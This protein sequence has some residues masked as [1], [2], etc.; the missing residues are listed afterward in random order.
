MKKSTVPPAKPPRNHHIDALKGVAIML[1]VLGHSIQAT[2][3]NMDTNWLFCWIYSFHMPLFMFLSGYIAF[4][5]NI[6]LRK[7]FRTLVIPFVVWYQISYLLQSLLSHH[8]SPYW[9]FIYRWLIS[10][11]WGLWFL[12]VLFLNFCLLKFVRA[13]ANPSVWWSE[14][15][16]AAGVY[17]LLQHPLVSAYGI[18]MASWYFAYFALGYFYVQYAKYIIMKPYLKFVMLLAAPFVGLTWNRLGMPTFWP[19]L[20]QFFVAN[21]IPG[22]TIFGHIYLTIVVPVVGIGA[23]YILVPKNGG[24]W[25]KYLCFLGMATFDIYVIHQNILYGLGSGAVLV[26]TRFIFAISV[27]LAIAWVLR[28]SKIAAF[29]LLGSRG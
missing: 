8:F 2:V 3:P 10:P 25:Y 27:S 23:T 15:V 14:P 29:L 13:V 16:V 22:I 9:P 17:L 6:D 21:H 18:G 20:T 12:W 19:Q 5:R 4:G 11:D 1:V 24:N 26:A 7:K 28:K